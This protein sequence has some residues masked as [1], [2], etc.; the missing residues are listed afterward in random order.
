LLKLAVEWR[1]TDKVPPRVEMLPGERH[2]DRVLSLEEEERYLNATTAVGE[3]I[4]ESYRRA[5][6]GIRATMRGEQPIEP[7]PPRILDDATGI[8]NQADER[9]AVLMFS[10]FGGVNN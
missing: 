2:R 6:E 10:V 5:L 9:L 1:K 7:D 8:V 3:G 4:Q